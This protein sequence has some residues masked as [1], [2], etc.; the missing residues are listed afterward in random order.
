MNIQFILNG[1]V[2]CLDTVAGRRVIDVLRDDL[3]LTGTKESCGSGE[4][5]AC[6]ILVDDES[7]LSCLMLAA[8]LEGRRVTTIEGIAADPA[9]AGLLHAFVRQ[10][11]VQC[12][13]CSPG[14][15]ISAVDLLR[16]NPRPQRAQIRAALS[17]NLCRCTG[18]QKIVDAVAAAAESPAA[19]PGT[20]G[21]T[22]EVVPE[23]KTPKSPAAP[24]AAP[25]DAS[26]VTEV[27][28][29]ETSAELLELTGQPGDY[30]LLAG[31]TDLLV[32]RREHPLAPCVFISLE[33]VPE[34]KTISVEADEIVI[35]AAVTFAQIAAA[36]LIQQHLDLLEQVVRVFGS[37]PITRMA[38]LGGNL[39]TASPA[40]DA[41]P[42]LYV[43]QAK[44][45]LRS[46]HGRR[47]T[48]LADFIC[49][50]RQIDLRPGEIVWAVHIPQPASGARGVYFKVG[51][52]QA[53]AIAVASLAAAWTLEP[54][55]SIQRIRLAWGSVGPRVMV[56]P[57]IEAALRGQRLSVERLKP[58]AA[59]VA[60]LV[61]P[62]DDLRASAAYRRQVAGNLLLKLAED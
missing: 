16:R 4:C 37:P 42:A 18:Y 3:R 17:G 44:V 46:L 48:P 27:I 49:G 7:R 8:Q 57:E 53:L 40:A 1:Q 14:M 13:Y 35:G 11:A 23:D 52:R 39:C 59:R 43:L 36:P 26:G 20:G 12:G 9:W 2:R 47:V 19:P 29:P 51:R 32:W 56:F 28:M 58:L 24:P 31:G 55:G 33:R 15:V 10:G 62:I 61:A 54:D 34:L 38:T 60:V 6:G 45:E 22:G 5:G 21:F 30:R 41:L 25:A 50:P